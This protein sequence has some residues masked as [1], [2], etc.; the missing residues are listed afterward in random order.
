LL[1]ACS[2]LLGVGF[3]LWVGVVG[4]VV[5]VGCPTIALMLEDSDQM[6]PGKEDAIHRALLAGLLGNVGMRS[7]GVE[8]S[9]VRGKK[10]YLFP[11]SSLFR[12]KPSWAMAAELVET[13]KLYARTVAS[14]H[15][16]W[17]ERVGSHLL[18]RT[19]TDPHW[20]AEIGRVLAYEKVMLQGLT[21]VPR[22]KVHYGPLEPRLSREIFIH[23]ALV[24][25]E[26]ETGAP[27][28][29]HNRRLIADVQ[30][31][32]ANRGGGMCWLSPRRGLSFTMRAFP[33]GFTRPRNLSDGGM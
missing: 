19:Y 23:H 8:Y 21:L 16:L 24:L 11:G 18:K 20:K 14:V 28:F 4:V 1:E 6:A 2:S 31:L 15:P 7:E 25:G 32:E 27:Y 9:G 33:S 17:I 29:E 3:G 30:S 5:G 10:F 22:R 26:Y 13:T 12:Q